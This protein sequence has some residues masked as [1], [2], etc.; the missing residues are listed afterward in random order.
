MENKRGGKEE[1]RENSKVCFLEKET[2]EKSHCVTVSSRGLDMSGGDLGPDPC[3]AREPTVEV[4]VK[5]TTSQSNLIHRD[6]GSVKIRGDVC[7][8]S[9]A[10]LEQYQSKHLVVAIE[11]KEYGYV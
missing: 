8:A 3:S 7:F 9:L 1:I 2:L 4:L 11:G 10:S 6:L 5:Q